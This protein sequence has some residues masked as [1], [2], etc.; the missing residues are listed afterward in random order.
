M[1]DAHFHHFCGIGK[2]DGLNRV[3]I[4]KKRH[5]FPGRREAQLALIQRNLRDFA[6]GFVHQIELRENSAR[7]NAQV[8]PDDKCGVFFRVPHDRVKRVALK[9]RFGFSVGRAHAR[10]LVR[11]AG[12]EICDRLSIREPRGVRCILD[13]S[14][15]RSGD[16]DFAAVVVEQ[17]DCL[18]ARRPA[19]LR[20]PKPLPSW[21]CSTARL[22]PSGDHAS[23][24]TM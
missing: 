15:L 9:Q 19:D 7:S 24:F 11:R 5:F 3:A 4:N 17:R 2:V 18:H 10:N 8:L 23:E 21:S 6:Y 20:E 12:R 22:C 16:F 1:P 14:R 13:E